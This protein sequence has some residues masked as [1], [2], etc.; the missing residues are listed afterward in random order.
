[1]KTKTFLLFMV[2]SIFLLVMIGGCEEEAKLKV[3]EEE[4]SSEQ[5]QTRL[6]KE[7]AW[8]YRVKPGTEEWGLLKNEEE[9]IA[10]VQIPEDVLIR[11]S[12][13][14]IVDL[15]VDFPL[16]GYFTAF[17]TPQEG[18]LIMLSRFNIFQHLLSRK[19]IGKDLIAVYKDAG[20]S[21]FEKMLYSN[22]FWTIKLKYLELIL[23][24]DEI[25]ESLTE[26]EKLELIIEAR[27]KLEKKGQHESFR[28][29]P[30]FQS[31]TLIMAQIL[32]IG[33]YDDFETYSNKQ[34][35]DKFIE[36]GLIEDAMLLIND[37][38]RLTD[39]FIKNANNQK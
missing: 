20:M 33:K 15:L 37:V 14:E 34:E 5:A 7:R 16:F 12:A 38:V 30:S 9:R 11:S 32:K 13:E 24:Q 19:D 6:A 35:M 23:S 4:Q 31:S 21:G 18:F 28:S 22:E 25:I 27:N 36:T 8:D 3:P 26:E 10:A 29:L 39:N 1:M 17:N 2:I